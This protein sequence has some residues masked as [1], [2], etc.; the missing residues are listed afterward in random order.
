MFKSAS[1]S[2]TTSYAND[3][4][5]KESMNEIIAGWDFLIALPKV[6]SMKNEL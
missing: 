1:A 4:I 6:F 3:H 2:P 5:G